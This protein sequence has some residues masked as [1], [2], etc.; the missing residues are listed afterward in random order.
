[1]KEY[2]FPFSPHIH[3]D[4]IITWIWLMFN[5]YNFELN[6]LKIPLEI[7]PTIKKQFERIYQTRVIEHYKFTDIEVIL[8]EM[9]RI[10]KI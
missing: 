7:L 3:V 4:A 2:K 1:M 8:K 5:G 9:I 6:S 10:T